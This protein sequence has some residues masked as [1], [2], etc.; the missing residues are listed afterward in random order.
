MKRSSSGGAKSFWRKGA[1]RAADAGSG[2]GRSGGAKCG[3]GAQYGADVSG[4]LDS[5]KDNE[6][7]SAC[8]SRGANEVV[9]RSLAGMDEC[10]NTLWVLGIGETLE[11]TVRG[12]ERGKGYLRPVDDG[13][14]TGVMTPAGFAEEHR[15]DAAAGTQC[16]FHEARSFDADE[17][18]F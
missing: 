3:G 2:G 4:V 17:S 8:R 6:Q 14:E 15:V 16:F 12:I 7:R 11:K 18:I 10:R 1:G 9:E 13:R 5:C